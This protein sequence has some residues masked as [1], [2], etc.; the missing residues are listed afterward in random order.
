MIEFENTKELQPIQSNNWIKIT[1]KAHICLVQIC[2][3]SHEESDFQYARKIPHP[4]KC[5]C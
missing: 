3:T 2:R 5:E 4:T 1:W